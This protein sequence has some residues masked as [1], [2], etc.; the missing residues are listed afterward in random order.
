[1]WPSSWNANPPPTTSSLSLL[2]VCVF[3]VLDEPEDIVRDG[4]RRLLSPFCKSL[5]VLMLCW[6]VRLVVVVEL[7][8]TLLTLLALLMGWCDRGCARCDALPPLA[9]PAADL[10]AD[11]L[12]PVCDLAAAVDVVEEDDDSAEPVADSFDS[13]VLTHSCVYT[14]TTRCHQLLLSPHS[15]PLR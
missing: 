11:L 12:L 13:I 10:D 9:V 6:L 5:Y 4:A 8:L 14:E 3:V 1:M 2:R 7:L 15:A